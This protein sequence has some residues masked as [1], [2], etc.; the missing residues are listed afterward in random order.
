MLVTIVQ[1]LDSMHKIAMDVVSK[2][3]QGMV[4]KCRYLTEKI[5]SQNYFDIPH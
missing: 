1:S 4:D 3:H 2:G 5:Q